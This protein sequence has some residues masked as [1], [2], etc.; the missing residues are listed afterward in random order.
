MS[1]CEIGSATPTDVFYLAYPYGDG[2]T[3]TAQFYGAIDIRQYG[4]A[5]D[6]HLLYT[7]GMLVQLYDWRERQDQTGMYL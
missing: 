5:E 6:A 1:R 4:P 7:L 3:G 2:Q